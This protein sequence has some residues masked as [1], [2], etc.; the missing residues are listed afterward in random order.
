LNNLLI[1]NAY[2]IRLLDYSEGE[3]FKH[4]TYGR[5]K[6]YVAWMSCVSGVLFPVG[7]FYEGR[8]AGLLLGIGASSLKQTEILSFF[9]EREH[10]GKNNAFKMLEFLEDKCREAKIGAMNTFYFDNRPFVP[11][12]NNLLDKCGFAP[13]EP[14]LFLC[15][16]KHEKNFTKM[17]ALEY[18][19]LPADFETFK[20]ADMDPALKEKLKNE[21]ENKEWFDNKLS[22]F[23]CEKT[24]APETSLWL[25]KCDDIVGWMICNYYSADTILY[26]SI[27]IMPE[28]QCAAL[29]IALLMRSIRA[30]IFS[31]LAE[32]YPY[33]LFE[34]RYD[35]QVMLK[36][37]RKMFARY[38]VEKYDRVTRKKIL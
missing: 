23:A 2:K 11:L 35:N 30:H 14:E 21:W 27:F 4:M 34:V 17:R 15:K 22:P 26:T 32:K 28:L 8:P 38:V 24:I 29:G 3:A 6:P 19:D 31:D 37:V 1:N 20:W 5:Y 25:R 13:A 16:C 33:A 12:I 10:R 18:T 9:I 36:M 7:L